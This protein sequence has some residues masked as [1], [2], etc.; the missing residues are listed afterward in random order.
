MNI[1]LI[2]GISD[3][4]SVKKKT[5][6]VGHSKLRG[7]DDVREILDTQYNVMIFFFR[8]RQFIMKTRSS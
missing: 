3:S 4:K 7:I 8:V 5:H 6:F 1:T 2:I